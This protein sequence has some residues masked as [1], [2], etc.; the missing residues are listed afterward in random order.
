MNKVGEHP[1]CGLRRHGPARCEWC[2]VGRNNSEIAVRETPREITAPRVIAIIVNV[3]FYPRGR[4]TCAIGDE[5][6]RG[7]QSWQ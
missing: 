7:I 2:R 3:G 5:D 6:V 1:S 4:P